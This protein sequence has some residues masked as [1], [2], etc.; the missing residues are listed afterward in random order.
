MLYRLQ[1]YLY[2]F[3]TTFILVTT[4]IIS[5]SIYVL[6]PGTAGSC[7]PINVFL[8]AGLT[9][10]EPAQTGFFQALGIAT[11]ITKG[12]IEVIKRFPLATAGQ[13]HTSCSLARLPGR[14]IY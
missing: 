1:I 6:I 5:T 13:V 8:E 9:G 7:A 2:T 14:N 11:K 3:Y 4:Y 12:N 10:M